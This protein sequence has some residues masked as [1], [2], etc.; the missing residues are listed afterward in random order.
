LQ[1]WF[2]GT[3]TPHGQKISK[4]HIPLAADIASVSAGMLFSEPPAITVEDAPAT[5]QAIDGLIDG[6]LHATLLEAADTCSGLGGTYLRIVWDRTITPLPWIAPVAADCAVPEFAYGTHLRAV[7]FWSTV[8]QDGETVW[9][10]LERHERGRIVHGLYQGTPLRLG[11]AV[12]LTEQPDTEPLAAL[13]DAEGSIDTGAPD[14]LTAVYVPNMRP[15]RVWRNCPSAAG[16]GQ[17]D[18]AGIEP[19]MDS[20][21][22]TYTSW[23]RDIRLGKSRIVVPN[24][25]L[26]SAGPGHGAQFLEDREMYSGLNFMPRAGDGMGQSLEVI[27]FKIRFE[28]HRATAQDLIEQV[29]GRAGYSGASFGMDAGGG[30]MTATEIT[31]RESKTITTRN[32][33]TL[34]WKPAIK[35]I[36]AAWLAVAAG[37]VAGARGIDVQEPTVE[38]RDGVA[39]SPQELAQTA[40][41][42]RTAQ[43]ASTDTLVRMLHPD[44]DDDQV[45]AEVEQITGEHGLGP[46]SDPTT[47]GAGGHGLDAPPGAPPGQ[48]PDGDEPPAT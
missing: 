48:E 34:Y 41:L 2:W 6:G 9:R 21:D 20:L 31:A 45:A 26:E 10:H 29:L 11:M 23:M 14:H 16:L 12:P 33:K 35:D 8:A 47:H 28:E 30:A 27:Q 24:A 25:M 42:L 39:D 43:A 44:W 18:Y 13:V 15:A 46:L 37:P 7:T 17:S 36:I 38:F 5:Q 3:E 4:L 40:A 22:E 1:R 19:L 32:R